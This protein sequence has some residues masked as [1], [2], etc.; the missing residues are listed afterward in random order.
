MNGIDFLAI[1]NRLRYLRETHGWS[2]A[3]ASDKSGLSESTIWKYETGNISNLKQSTIENLC[4]LYNVNASYIIYG[5]SDF[6]E[7]AQIELNNLKI[8]IV[9]KILKI[10]EKN[11]LEYIRMTLNNSNF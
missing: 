10:N 6:Q 9:T 5:I 3:Y 7:Q 8:D 4:S 11:I 2:L 1:G